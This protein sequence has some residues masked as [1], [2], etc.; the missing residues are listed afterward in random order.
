MEISLDSPQA[1]FC[2]DLLM[3]NGNATRVRRREKVK[4]DGRMHFRD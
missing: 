1:V 3:Q 2:K 4:K